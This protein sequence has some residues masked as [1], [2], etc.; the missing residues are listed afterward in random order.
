MKT[1]V[2]DTAAATRASATHGR[3][4][5][6]ARGAPERVRARDRLLAAADELFYEDGIHTVGIDRVIERAG[7][8]KATLYDTFG[9]KE[10]LVRAYLEARHEARRARLDAWL[11]RYDDPRERLLG[12]FDAMAD[13]M[14]SKGFRGCAFMR[15][16]SESAPTSGVRT[17]CD[18]ARGW[19]RDLFARLARD[20]GVPADRVEALA[21]QLSM[22]YDGASVLGQ[23]EGSPRAAIAAR[24]A[25][26]VLIDGVR[27]PQKL[28]RRRREP[29]GPNR[30]R[31]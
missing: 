12:V 4:R 28:N 2:A 18:A 20:A 7:V 3:G 25:A 27:P 22:L 1:P 6:R 16:G 13:L 31:T 14:K 15:A 9:S 29:K 10:A 17:A 19:M 21:V 30:S 24:D 8:A 5:A 26:T 23:I 11:Q